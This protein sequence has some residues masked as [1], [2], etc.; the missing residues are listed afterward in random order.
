MWKIL[1]MQKIISNKSFS[2]NP[3]VNILLENQPGNCC[4]YTH[5]LV[6]RRWKDILHSLL[7]QPVC[8][9]NMA[10]SRTMSLTRYWA[11]KMTHITPGPL[12][13]IALSQQT[14]QVRRDW[15]HKGGRNKDNNREWKEQHRT[16][17][18]SFS[19]SHQ[20]VRVA[21]G[22]SNGTLLGLL[23][24]VR[25]DHFIRA[26]AKNTHDGRETVTYS[27]AVKHI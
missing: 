9:T 12:C 25:W 7:N 8:Y 24:L 23:V 10:H 27:K 20:I 14:G 13:H 19:F 2:V 16:R 3:Q 26:G 15:V 4:T 5:R 1:L 22:S 17:W 11:W 6:H 21:V 18:Y